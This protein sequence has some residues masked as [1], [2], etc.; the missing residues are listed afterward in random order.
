MS[1]LDNNDFDVDGHESNDNRRNQSHHHLL[2]GLSPEDVEYCIGPSSTCSCSL[3]VPSGEAE[4]G[5]S[6]YSSHI[7]NAINEWKRGH[8]DKE[9]EAF[10]PLN[11][12]LAVVSRRAMITTLY[13]HGLTI[14]RFQLL[15]EE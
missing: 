14:R 15:L 6:N 7:E 5:S 2:E 10:N 3:S 11:T 13:R 4:A 9:D 8:F 12:I 1:I